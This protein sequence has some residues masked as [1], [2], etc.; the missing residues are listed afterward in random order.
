MT[1]LANTTRIFGIIGQSNAVMYRSDPADLPVSAVDAEIPFTINGGAGFTPTAT[2]ITYLRP[3]LIEDGGGNGFSDPGITIPAGWS[4]HGYGVEMMLART[5]HSADRPVA[6]VKRAAGSTALGNTGAN[7]YYHNVQNPSLAA[8]FNITDF[9]A[10]MTAMQA[11]IIGLG[12][13]PI[14]AGIYDNQGEDDA[15]NL[16]A[17]GEYGYHKARQVKFL[18]AMLGSEVP[19]VIA[20]TKRGGTSDGRDL[21]NRGK[22]AVARNLPGVAIYDPPDTL[23]VYSDNLHFWDDAAIGMGEQVA[24][25]FEGM[26]V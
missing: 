14:V 11:H 20:L 24:A 2:D 26:G 6:V 4:S 12:R 16:T 17:A 1:Y 22:I 9:L 21:V 3:Q 10:R 19:F 18:R 7:P 5:L 13:Q 8:G 15:A 23:P 25:I